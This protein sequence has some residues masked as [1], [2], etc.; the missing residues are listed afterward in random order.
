VVLARNYPGGT[1]VRCLD[2]IAGGQTTLFVVEREAPGKDTMIDLLACGNGIS[3]AL[4][5]GLWSSASGVP[6][7]VKTVSGLQEFS[8]KA[9]ALLPLGIHSISVSPSPSAHVFAVLDTVSEAD[10]AGVKLGLYGK[11]VMVWGGNSEYQLGN[12]RRSSLAVPQHL[13]P[14]VDRPLDPV[15]EKSRGS[16]AD[17]S[18]GTRS[19]MPHSRLQLHQTRTAAYDLEGKLL[20]R[21]VTCEETMVAGY[22]ASV[23]YNKIVD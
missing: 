11:D 17:M 2:I 9:Q 18:S 6:A 8:E 1:A 22:N 20:K 16:G 14:L 21:R 13:P 4:G 12:G 10:E 19:P 7:R 3:G 5:N 23:L 15:V